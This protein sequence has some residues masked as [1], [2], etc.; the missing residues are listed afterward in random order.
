MN[1]LFWG[2]LVRTAEA[3]ARGGSDVTLWVDSERLGRYSSQMSESGKLNVI[4][5][6]Q[7]AGIRGLYRLVREL[8]R[9]VRQHDIDVVFTNGVRD[10]VV[11]AL[12]CRFLHASNRPRLV[13]TSHDSYTW[14]HPEKA[15]LAILLFRLLSDAVVALASFVETAL[16]NANFPQSRVRMIPNA[17]DTDSMQPRNQSGGD[18]PVGIGYVGVV[19]PMKGQDVLIKALRQVISQHPDVQV[20]FFGDIFD[21]AYKEN[22][23][24]Y[25]RDQSM[26]DSVKFWG[27]TSN[28]EALERLRGLDIY[29]CPSLMEMCPYNV[30]EAE[31]TGLPVVA[32]NVG[33]IP[34]LID[35]GVEGILFPPGDAG[36]LAAAL[37]RLIGDPTE[38]QRMGRMAR[39]RAVTRH[40]C[41]VIGEQLTDFFASLSRNGSQQ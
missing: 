2:N 41:A 11:A 24:K 4:Y 10:L 1:I 5:Y 17:V 39:A 33:G 35:D 21:E 9:H 40:D 26:E 22:M 6:R 27:A 12:A 19:N 15:R 30:I 7:D 29:V 34:D 20:H 16:R 31:A 3:L 32:S 36:A 13:S 18:G 37:C 23:A 14:Q 8:R 38:R 28:E 25:I